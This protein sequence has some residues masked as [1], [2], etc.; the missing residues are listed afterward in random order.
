MMEILNFLETGLLDFSAWQI[1]LT[2]FISVQITLSGVSLFLHREQTHRGIKLHPVIQHFY[3]FWMWF[4][5]GMLTKDW[6]AIHRKHH[7]HCET[8]EDPHS[9]QIH[10]I[11]KVLFHGVTLYTE[12]RK[13]QETLDKYGKGTP[14]DW[15]ERNV[16]TKFHFYGIFLLAAVDL[17]LFGI[18]GGAVFAIQ[19]IWIPFFAA[20]VINGVGHY[21]GYRNYKTDDSSRNITRFAFFIMGEELHNNHHA[22]PSSS[23]FAHKKGEYDLGWYMIK[24]LNKLGLCEI[25]KVVPELQIDET[26]VEFSNETVKAILTHKF[27]VMQLYIKDVINP[28][29]NSEFE[30]PN[31]DV[32]KGIKKYT[33]QLS[34]DPQFIKSKRKVK[35]QYKFEDNQTMQSLMAYKAELQAIWDNNSMSMEEMIEA[36]KQW[37]KKAEASGNKMLQDFAAS[38]KQYKLN[39]YV[40]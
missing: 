12:E 26:Q 9:P 38:L 22:F 32:K 5:T 8:E 28:N 11:K 29:L 34:L 21:F 15:M 33:Q 25:K 17:A 1:V 27:N 30:S 37:C 7:A 39:P 18:I 40:S 31:K 6:V 13:N 16:Y 3:R 2:V 36:F 35:L 20:G 4:T 10:G 24:G 23:K 19:V 14:D